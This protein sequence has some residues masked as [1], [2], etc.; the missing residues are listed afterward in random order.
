[1]RKIYYTLLVSLVFVCKGMLGQCPNNNVFWADLTPTGVG[2]TQSTSCNFFGDYNTVTVCNGATYSISTCGTSSGSGNTAITIFNNAGGA[3]LTF[4]NSDNCTTN[5]ETMTYTATFNGVIRILIDRGSGVTCNGSNSN[6]VA[7]DVTQI[8]AGSASSAPGCPT[9]TS[10]ANSTTGLCSSNISLVWTAPASTCG[11]GATSY[12]LSYGTNAAATNIANNLNV[13]NVTSYNVGTLSSSTTY[14][15]KITATNAVGASSGCST[16]SF[17]TASSCPPLDCSGGVTICNDQTVPGNASGFGTQ[18]LSGTNQGCLSVEHQSSWYAFSPSASGNFGLTISPGGAIDYD[19][20]LW[21]PY[22]VGST[23]NTICPPSTTPI[24]C[25][26]ASGGTTNSATGSYNTGMGN[27]S[28]ETSPQFAAPGTVNTDGTAPDGTINGWTRGIIGT[29]GQV[30]VLLVDNFTSD[31]TPFVLDWNLSGGATLNCT[32]L[33]FNLLSFKGFNVNE[34]NELYWSTSSEMDSYQFMIEK[35]DNGKD[36]Y[37]I[38]KIDGAI[39]STTI[40]DYRFTDAEPLVGIN[41]YR[42]KQTDVDGITFSNII[43]IDYN[44]KTTAYISPN[45][46]SAKECRLHMMAN[47]INTFNVKITDSFGRSLCEIETALEENIEKSVL[48]SD[49]AKLN[50]GIYFISITDKRGK[51]VLKEKFII[52]E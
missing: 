22:A 43:S 19:W 21:G 41:Y 52:A 49:I 2:N 37:D 20:A 23:L 31:G 24:R 33:G 45:P 1:M 17:T 29:V 27:N 25:S 6:C 3:A 15:W 12:S 7:M 16:F 50:N 8:T 32:T 28:W 9:L 36:F 47:Y 14:Y 38:G 46:S 26:Y 10:P 18:E 51:I 11:N 35:S 34:K 5:Q 4:Q 48:L 44:A 39:N 30:Y 13:G 42:L 40:Q